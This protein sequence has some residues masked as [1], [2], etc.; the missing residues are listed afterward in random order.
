MS[1]LEVFFPD[2]A[3]PDVSW[4]RIA[5]TSASQIAVLALHAARTMVRVRGLGLAAGDWVAATFGELIP[6][7]WNTDATPMWTLDPN[8]MWSA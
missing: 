3:D 2:P 5:D 1:E 4:T 6:Q 8:P 7:M